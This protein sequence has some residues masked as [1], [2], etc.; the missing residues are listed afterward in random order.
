VNSAVAAFAAALGGFIALSYE[1]L[2]YRALTIASGGMAAAF[3]LLLAFYLGGLAIGARFAGAWC[4]RLQSASVS[5]ADTQRVAAGTFGFLLTANLTAAA[6]LPGLAWAASHGVWSTALLLVAIAAGL[7]GTILPLVSHLAVPP[8]SR[9]GSGISRLYAANIVGSVTGS[10]LTGFVLLDFLTTPALAALLLAS[11][12]VL[13][14]V[15]LALTRPLKRTLIGGA[16]GALL[17]AT[18]GAALAPIVL[19]RFYER[20]LFGPAA[21]SAPDFAQVVENRSGVVTVTPDGTIYGTGAYDGRLSTDLMT[22]QNMIERAYAVA[23]LHPAPRT[24]LMIGLGGGAWAQ[25]VANHPALTRMTIVEINPGYQ[26]VIASHPEVASLLTNPKVDLVIDDGRRWLTRHPQSRFDVIVANTTQHWRPHAT[27]LLSVEYLRLIRRHLRP[28]GVYYFNTT[29]S[30]AVIRTAMTEYPYGIR[31]LNF[32]AVSDAPLVYDRARFRR[33]LGEY[34]I[35]G[36]PVLD[37]SSAEGRRRLEQVVDSMDIEER[38]GVLAKYGNAPLVTDDNMYPE[39]HP[40]AQLWTVEP[41]SE[42]R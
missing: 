29:Y 15:L 25:V 28:G 20:L 34:K 19:A 38:A 13:A 33:V 3:G 35:D 41:R 10:F 24:V 30:P 31:V 36:R 9:S 2:W 7:L 12:C 14:L 37:V 22:D 6:V 17:L 18:T 21:K 8:D 42:P 4:G 11:G 1:I 39:W 26:Q 23:A 16:V 32:A 40:A 27:N 5:A